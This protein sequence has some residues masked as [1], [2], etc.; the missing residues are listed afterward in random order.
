MTIYKYSLAGCNP[1]PLASYLKSL[2]ILRIVAKQFD[3]SCRGWWENEQFQLLST[4]PKE[5]FEEFFLEQYEPSPLVSPWNKGCGFFKAN[6]PGL[7]PLEKSIAKRFEI[8][9]NGITASRKLL[10]EIATADEMIRA[11][12][13]STK[14]D[15]TFQTDDQRKLIR[16]SHITAETIDKIRSEISKPGLDESVKQKL[17]TELEIIS[18]LMTNSQKPASA[19]E[20]EDLKIHSGYRRLLA[21]SERHFKTLK[22]ALISNC[23]RLWRGPHAEWLSSAVVLD[24][25]DRPDWP[26]LLGTGGNDGRLDFTNTFMYQLAELFDLKSPHGSPNPEA[27]RLLQQSLWGDP[28]NDL[29]STSIGQFMPGSAGGFNSSTGIGGSPFVNPWD[30][31]LM[32]EGTFL[33]S[34]RATRRLCPNDSSRASA[35]FA[36]RAHAAGYASPGTEKAQRGEQWM[37]IW[38][39]PA[40]FSDISS[41][42][43]EA[44]LQ[45]KRQ[46]AARPIEAVRAINRLG[47]V[48]G[49]A[50]FVRYGYLER[51]G[52]S[53]LAVP[54]GRIKVTSHPLSYLIDDVASWTERIQLRARDS[55]APNSLKTAERI[56]SDSILNVLTRNDAGNSNESLWQTVLEACVEIECLQRNGIA[57][58][59]GPIPPL[60]PAWIRAIGNGVEVRLA[61]ALASAA[62]TYSNSGLPIDLVRSHWLPL[63]AGRFAKFNTSEKRLV[64]D[65]RVVMSGRDFVGDCAAVVQRRIVEAEKSSKRILPLVAF[66]RCGVSLEDVEAFITGEVDDRLIYVLSRALMAV[67]WEQLR[68]EHLPK[69]M[70][71]L[72]AKRSSQ[73]PEEAWLMLRLVHL[74]RALRDGRSIP[75]EPSIVRLLQSNSADRAID[76]S[77]RRLR[78]VGIRP[79]L[80]YGNTDRETA[81]RWAA[82]LAFPLNP[83][84]IQRA[85]ELV[86]PSLRGKVHD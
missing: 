43:G 68:L 25:D 57:I 46:I 35:P 15:R 63:K 5:I 44:R 69:S 27:A 79:P 66:P 22:E 6:D 28:T 32:L 58:D 42:F 36:I 75:V 76:I 70:S 86:D 40:T 38:S 52:Q 48:R 51:N 9:R 56:L 65:P 14:R 84:S 55:Y 60:N 29:R 67:R 72:R 31:V 47:A 12:K 81:C 50:S 3:S 54:L 41:M 4:K 39:K 34:A 13:A 11:I 7:M 59:A 30:F 85:A 49:I 8:F 24:Q 83:G 21:A 64:N 33:F 45:L 73:V 10:E 82:A 80:Y 20:A 26:S 74:P 37:P 71:A 17:Y 23:R 16:S 62:A 78:S 2:G 61:L 53:T 1:T 18:R 77:S 19:K